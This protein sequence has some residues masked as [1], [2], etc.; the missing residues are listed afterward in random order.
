MGSTEIT[1]PVEDWR[2]HIDLSVAQIDGDLLSDYDSQM[3][4]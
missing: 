3:T 1:L 4:G 2:L